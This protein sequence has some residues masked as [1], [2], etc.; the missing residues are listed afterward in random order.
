MLPSSVTLLKLMIHFVHMINI[1]RKALYIEGFFFFFFFFFIKRAFEFG[2]RLDTYDQISFKFGMML[3]ATKMYTL[4][5][6]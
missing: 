6:V 4:I 1:Q 3:D 5:P 2:L